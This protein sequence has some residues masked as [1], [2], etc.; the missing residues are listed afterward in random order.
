[1]GFGRASVYA[2]VYLKATSHKTS[3]IT[4][5]RKTIWWI[6]SIVAFM[7]GG[8]F[9][10]DL[11]FAGMVMEPLRNA[12][13]AKS[14][15]LKAVQLYPSKT[16]HYYRYYRLSISK[17]LFCWWDLCQSWLSL[18]NSLRN[19]QSQVVFLAQCRGMHPKFQELPPFSKLTFFWGWVLVK[20]S[21]EPHASHI[22][23]NVVP[24]RGITSQTTP[25]T[26]AL[27]HLRLV[28]LYLPCLE[29][30]CMIWI[31]V[32]PSSSVTGCQSDL[33]QRC[34]DSFLFETRNVNI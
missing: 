11:Y 26:T 6:P 32:N 20:Y 13:P 15:K 3:N 18:A 16:T 31:M 28:K 9:Y 30:S 27:C 33:P 34:E 8:I 29:S 23:L 10:R 24:Q 14:K 17:V 22:E 12:K 4:Y 2:G 25:R 21:W 19:D 1:M 5:R 7:R